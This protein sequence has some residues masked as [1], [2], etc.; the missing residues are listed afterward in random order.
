[1]MRLILQ[2]VAALA[3]RAKVRQP[4]IGRIAIKHDARHAESH[5]LH[6][7][8]PSGRPAAQGGKN[9]ISRS[10]AATATAL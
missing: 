6:E 7:V 5:G 8:R 2:Q 4:I 3:E 10:L 1:M 9:W